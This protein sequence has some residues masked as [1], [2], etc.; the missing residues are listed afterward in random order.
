MNRQ[1]WAMARRPRWLLALAGCLI[2]AAIFG[3]LGQWQAERAIQQATIVTPDTESPV[4]LESI[5]AP[6]EPLPLVDGGRRVTVTATWSSEAVVIESKRQSGVDGEWLLRNTRLANGACLAVVVGWGESVNP[7]DYIFVDDSPSLLSGRIVGSDDPAEG[8]YDDG[9]LTIV[10]AADLVNRWDCDEIFN[11]YVV[12]DSAPAPL[13]PVAAST[14]LPQASLNWLN[15]FYALEWLFFA[16]FALY[17][18][19]RLVKDAVERE[20]E[21]ATPDQP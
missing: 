12:L 5:I 10:S 9:R 4:G 7:S 21:G 3:A 2:L 19:Y 11:A 13:I 14:P 1:W 6:G 16:G 18:W 8:D 17:F 20:T 15:I